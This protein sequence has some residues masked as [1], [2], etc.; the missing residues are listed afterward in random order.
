VAGAAGN[1]IVPGTFS[2]AEFAASPAYKELNRS[3]V[4]RVMKGKRITSVVDVGCEAGAVSGLIAEHLPEGATLIG[5]DPSATALKGWKKS[6]QRFDQLQT[7]FVRG[8]AEEVSRL[9]T[10]PVD[11]VFFCNA[12]H[13]V[14]DKVHVV[15]E[16]SKSL[17]PGGL[18]AFNSAFFQGAE[19]EDTLPFYRAWMFK[20][21]RRLRQKHKLS[22]QREK[23]P[24]RMGL[25][26]DEYRQI[27]EE[28]GFT[29]SELQ[30][31]VVDLPLDTCRA[32]TQ[33]EGFIQGVLPGVP[34]EIGLEV[35]DETIG[36]TFEALNM[37]VLP[38]NWLLAVA[39]KN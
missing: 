35:L 21:L 18:F 22:P 8:S 3:F 30:V 16:I 2:F 20:A 31:V 1:Q 7:R 28:A 4:G 15:G 14:Q 37:T 38:R 13:L 19:L 9:V 34:L 25:T 26:P 12:L 33:F 39:V 36:E 23:V 10:E 6:L 27:L 32:L 17:K 11:A 24:A 29:V 5:I